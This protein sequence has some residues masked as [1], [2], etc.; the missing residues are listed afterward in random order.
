[1]SFLTPTCQKTTKA[2]ITKLGAHECDMRVLRHPDVAMILGPKRGQ[3]AS[4]EGVKD[5]R[6][7]ER[8]KL[9][10]SAGLDTR[11]NKLTG[12]FKILNGT[13]YSVNSDFIFVIDVG[14]RRRLFRKLCKSRS[15]LV[16]RK[17]VSSKSPVDNWN[18]ISDI[19]SCTALNNFTSHLRLHWDWKPDSR[20]TVSGN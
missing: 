5:L 13:N 12:T 2:K 3:Q 9:F 1:M 19:C 20:P 17:F 10:G 8:L 18:S 14:G 11:R 6:Y 4:I 15:G 16:V 7:E